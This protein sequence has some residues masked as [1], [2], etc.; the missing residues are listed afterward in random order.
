[1]CPSKEVP[2][3][4]CQVQ[5]F[6]TPTSVPPSA[7]GPPPAHKALSWPALERADFPPCHPQGA[8]EA[9]DEIERRQFKF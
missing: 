7:A 1:V 6:Q 4:G 5:P 3:D 2:W 8:K 9:E